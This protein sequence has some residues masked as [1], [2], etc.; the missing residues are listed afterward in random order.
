ML[1][2]GPFRQ[3]IEERKLAFKIISL[4]CSFHVSLRP[5]IF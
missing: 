4:K 2:D 1:K 5:E 3:E